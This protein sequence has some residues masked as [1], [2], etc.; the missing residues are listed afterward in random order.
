MSHPISLAHYNG[1]VKGTRPA[2]GDDP[3]QW[4]HT[5]YSDWTQFHQTVIQEFSAPHCHPGGVITVAGKAIPQTLWSV[6]KRLHSKGIRIIND[7]IRLQQRLERS[8]NGGRYWTKQRYQTIPLEEDLVFLRYLDEL[9]IKSERWE[10]VKDTDGLVIQRNLKWRHP[11]Y[12]D[13][14]KGYLWAHM[15]KKNAGTQYGGPI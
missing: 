2:T 3:T 13:V 12:K 4:P 15:R 7:H 9:L 8:K 1:I 14:V 6:L 11:F 5:V 10:D